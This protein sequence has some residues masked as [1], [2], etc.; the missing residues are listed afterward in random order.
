[1][2]NAEDWQNTEQFHSDVMEVEGWEYYVNGEHPYSFDY[3][4]ATNVYRFEVRDGDQ[5]TS[6]R[7]SD[8]A[9]SER[10]EVSQSFRSPI[11][12]SGRYVSF[13]GK[14]KVPSGVPANT[15][16]WMSVK[17]FHSG[18][19]RSGPFDMGPRGSDQ[20]KCVVRSSAGEQ[21][22]N[23]TPG[24]I[25]R[26]KEYDIKVDIK[27]DPSTAAT[28]YC[29][30]YVD[31]VR[32]V[33]LNNI[34]IG[35][36]DQ[37]T[38]HSGW[39]CYRQSP[40]ANETYVVEWRDPQDFFSSTAAGAGHGAPVDDTPEE[41]PPPPTDTGWEV[42]AVGP[43]VEIENGPLAL[44]VPS[45]AAPGDTLV[46]HGVKDANGDFTRPTG[47]TA[48]NPI[49]LPDGSLLIGARITAG[50][51]PPTEMTFTRTGGGSA[52]GFVTILRKR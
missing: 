29:H 43:S 47:S 41:P 23:L 13:V 38:T 32:V 10:A 4:P 33:N 24:A 36:T 16:P 1:M 19:N 17:Q 35:Y 15:A 42:V 50:A 21:V 11:N 27:F 22:Y 37:T 12:G 30:V 8:V 45:G 46:A 25:V 18:L 52:A 9:G 51:T 48:W 34:R 49:P 14:F 2:Y 26:G 44:P 5:F 28:G 31:G 3:N 6:N 20:L 7:F 40:P 39:G